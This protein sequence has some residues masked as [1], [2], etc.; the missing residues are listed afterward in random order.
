MEGAFTL[1]GVYA[2]SSAEKRD[3]RIAPRRLRARLLNSAYG[4]VVFLGTSLN[5]CKHRAGSRKIGV[6]TCAVAVPAL[7]CCADLDG[8][9]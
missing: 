2:S 5:A 9:A 3:M 7:V 8:K 4:G 1:L 6:E